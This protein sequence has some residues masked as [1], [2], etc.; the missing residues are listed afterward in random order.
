[1]MRSLDRATGA[2]IARVAVVQAAALHMPD[3]NDLVAERRQALG[4]LRVGVSVGRLVAS[5][6]VDRTIEYVARTRAVDALVIVG[7]GPERPR[8]ERL[9]RVC[10]VDARFVGLVSRHEALAWIGAADVLLHAS[11]AEGLSTVARE[12]DALGTPV[13]RVG[14]F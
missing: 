1:L 12:A 2:R 6:R 7:D 11:E 4:N 5:K 8:L 3:M 14:V 13:R 9:A 10:D